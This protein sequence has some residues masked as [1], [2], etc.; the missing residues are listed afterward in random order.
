M[1]D[2]TL[3]LLA[4]TAFH[5]ALLQ[6]LEATSSPES[7]ELKAVSD[8]ASLECAVS[9]SPGTV[10]L[11]AF[12]TEVIVPSSVLECCDAGAYNFHP[13]P[14]E[15]PGIF[16]SC[17]AIYDGAT[18]FGTTA[19]CMTAVVDGGGIVAVTRFD[20]PAGVDRLQLDSLSF[21]AVMTQFKGMVPRL[22]DLSTEL[23]PQGE[24]WSGPAR[25]RKHFEQLCHL[26]DGVSEEEFERRYRAVGEGPNHAL[27]L[28]I[29]GHRFRLD[30]M[31][32]DDS[33]V[34]GGQT[35]E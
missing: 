28:E 35:T 17:F 29:Y 15:Y 18:S 21:E 22:I 3:I 34:R 6:P 26:P 16:P 1:T 20:M 13:G 10:R 30:N 19:H 27:T 5:P 31:R 4:D 11:I 12:C 9:E 23:T 33:V 7:P 32:G 24:E 8:R 14:P 2:Q 25:T